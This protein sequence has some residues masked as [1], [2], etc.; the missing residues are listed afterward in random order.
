MVAYL[1]KL[2]TSS[3]LTSLNITIGCSQGF[4]FNNFL[5]YGLH[6]LRTTCKEKYENQTSANT[7]LR[8]VWKQFENNIPYVL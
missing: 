4:A 8:T 7:I 1:N 5:K 2:S 6:A 3:A